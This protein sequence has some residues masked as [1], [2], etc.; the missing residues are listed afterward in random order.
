MKP[1]WNG[2]KCAWVSVRNWSNG[3]LPMRLTL[4]PLKAMTCGM[5]GQP[6]IF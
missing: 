3:S 4:N 6:S 2:F 1:P 5:I